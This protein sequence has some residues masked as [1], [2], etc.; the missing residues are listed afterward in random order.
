[1]FSLETK[2]QC[3]ISESVA[4]FGV[5]TPM[6]LIQCF[7]RH[8]ADS[9]LSPSL[10]TPKHDGHPVTWLVAKVKPSMFPDNL[11]GLKTTA[12]ARVRRGLAVGFG[13]Q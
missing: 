7:D 6:G 10:E 11:G 5:L 9:L 2:D 12:A 3:Y 13:R 8:G 4:L 1:M